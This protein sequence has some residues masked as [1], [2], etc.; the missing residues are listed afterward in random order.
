MLCLRSTSQKI[1]A[2]CL[3]YEMR[4]EK[5][6]SQLRAIEPGTVWSS[7]FTATMKCLSSDKH[8][9]LVHYAQETTLH[10][11]LMLRGMQDF[12]KQQ[13]QAGRN[14]MLLSD[15]P[16]VHNFST[17]C[18]GTSRGYQ[19]TPS[20]LTLACSPEP[21][22]LNWRPSPH[23]QESSI[24]DPVLSRIVVAMMTVTHEYIKRKV[25]TFQQVYSPNMTYQCRLIKLSSFPKT[26]LSHK[27]FKIRNQYPK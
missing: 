7:F 19:C 15:D 5:L 4:M 16:S 21:S 25:T 2:N 17:L 10:F 23:Q 20:I 26:F 11:G 24:N 18:P 6:E 22:F 12:S 14:P 27:T 3:C 13:L 9:L 8:A 1:Q